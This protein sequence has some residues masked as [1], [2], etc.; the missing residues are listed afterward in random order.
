MTEKTTTGDPIERIAASFSGFADNIAT[1]VGEVMAEQREETRTLFES[2]RPAEPDPDNVE[3]GPPAEEP[4]E[5]TDPSDTMVDQYSAWWSDPEK[6][7]EENARAIRSNFEVCMLI[8]SGA[9]RLEMPVELNYPEEFLTAARAHIFENRKMPA[10]RVYTGGSDGAYNARNFR[11]LDVQRA[12]D[13]QESGFGSDLVDVQYISEMWMAAR[14][15][16]T[17]VN[18]IRTVPM[19]SATQV[20]PID[21][22][23]PEMHLVS[24][25]TSAGASLYTTSKTASSSRTLTSKKFT[26]QQDWSAELEEDSVIAFVPFL[27]EMLGESAALHLGSAYYN[28]DTTSA[29]TG[30]INLDDNTPGSTKH[31]LAWDGIRHYW[32][33]DAAGQGKD[34]AAALD[35]AE[36]NV[37]RGKLNG[38]DDD[39]DASV[40]NVNWGTDPRDL[41]IVCDWATYTA[42]LDADR[43]TTVDKY[44]AGA[45]VLTG[46]LGAFAGIP[47]IAP[48]YATKTDSDGK[49]VDTEASNTKGQLTVFAP[50]GFIGGVRRETQL[51]FGRIQGQ[52]QFKFELYSRRAFQ[53][54]G[55]NVAAGIY[56][57]T[58]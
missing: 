58:L 8:S 2:L 33:V 41:R 39:V 55:A 14:N 30:N 36:I 7:P 13:S 46:E 4:P 15:R 22:A 37:A 34:M 28:G 44:G 43:V 6:S 42:M 53:R 27:R 9:R 10:P 17:I 12:M 56:D 49:A 11:P 24:E 31:Y 32:L 51:F 40:G 26:I 54:H 16:D 38:A 19:T 1:Q 47:I 20:I 5:R 3:P 21:G 48:S 50:R 57:I 25:K 23:V 45:T 29:G 35:I 52:D 18:D